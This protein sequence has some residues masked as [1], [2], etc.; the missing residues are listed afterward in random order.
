MIRRG[1]NTT[2]MQ[3][4]KG[5]ENDI[6]EVTALY[7][8][9]NDY[10]ESHTNYPGWRKG[11]YPTRVD[12]AQGIAENNLFVAVIAGRIAG[13]SILRHRPEEAYALADWG[14]QS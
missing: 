11:I 6:E 8:A 9:L 5:T 14:K 4:R 12:V 7:D 3:I 10:L 13:T 2:T 1:E